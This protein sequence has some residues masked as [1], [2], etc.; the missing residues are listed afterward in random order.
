MDPFGLDSVEPR[1]F[2]RQPARDDAHPTVVLA[3]DRLIV[4]TH[5]GFDLLAHPAW[6]ALSQINTKT[7]L[8]CVWT[9]LHN[10]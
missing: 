4:L 7:F 1:T 9:C 5:P 3:Q 2:C 8:S 10:H 6:E